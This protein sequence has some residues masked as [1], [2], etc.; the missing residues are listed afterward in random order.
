MKDWHTEKT[1][2]GYYVDE[3]LSALQKFIRRNHVEDACWIAYELYT[4]SQELQEVLWQRLLIIS[5]EDIGLE[6]PMANTIVK[7][8]YDT[9]KVFE[10]ASPDRPMLFV[11]AIRYLCEAKK[12]RG[13]CHLCSITK[14]RIRH[15]DTIQLPDFVYDMHTTKGR[16]MQRGYDHF[17]AEGSQVS[18]RGERN[19]TIL[20]E[21]L[22]QWIEREKE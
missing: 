5:V 4:T 8:L 13:T 21:T 22:K 1:P 17:L 19:D 10:E 6:D 15:H 3:C 16:E 9:N 14:R 18:P 2:H 12:E 11:Q 20:L 7:S